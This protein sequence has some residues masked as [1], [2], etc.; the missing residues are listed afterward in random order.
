MKS[1]SIWLKLLLTI[2]SFDGKGTFNIIKE[3]VTIDEVKI[4]DMLVKL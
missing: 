2:G 1:K 3:S 4:L